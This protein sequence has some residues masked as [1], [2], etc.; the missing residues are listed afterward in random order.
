MF[1]LINNFGETNCRENNTGNDIH[2]RNSSK[3]PLPWTEPSQSLTLQINTEIL[4]KT[5]KTSIQKQ[6]SAASESFCYTFKEQIDNWDN[7]K[8]SANFCFS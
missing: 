8:H 5:Q 3:Q 1:P 4:T 2:N 6:L 7:Y